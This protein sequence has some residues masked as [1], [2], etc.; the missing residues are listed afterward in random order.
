MTKMSENQSHINHM[1]QTDGFTNEFKISE[2]KE[3]DTSPVAKP[4]KSINI[5]QEISDSSFSHS[6]HSSEKF[7]KPEETDFSP[8][9]LNDQRMPDLLNIETKK[10]KL[11]PF[12]AMV[13]E[14]GENELMR[15][16]CTELIEKMADEI[17]FDG[18]FGGIKIEDQV[19]KIEQSIINIDKE[20][21]DFEEIK[22]EV[23]DKIM[24]QE[25]Y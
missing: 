18:P 6:L 24:I 12:S 10:L 13:Q 3:S 5:S 21:T 7:P 15:I 25:I 9:K 20:L 8:R 22:D 4:L 19:K 16:S 14:N 17:L 2:D 1:N 11:I 23:D